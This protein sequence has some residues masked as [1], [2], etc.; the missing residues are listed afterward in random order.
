MGQDFGK[1]LNS[2]FSQ[3]QSM[4]VGTS[5]GKHD[6]QAAYSSVS[7]NVEGSD[8]MNTAQNLPR[9]NDDDDDKII[10]KDVPMAGRSVAASANLPEHWQGKIFNFVISMLIGARLGKVNS[11]LTPHREPPAS[12]VT[13]IIT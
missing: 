4:A 1:R 9:S 11:Y 7:R 6:P 5:G 13:F 2:T 10:N 12:C 3:A 8:S